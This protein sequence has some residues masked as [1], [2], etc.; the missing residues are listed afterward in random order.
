MLPPVPP[1][2]QG[3]SYISYIGYEGPSMMDGNQTADS[4][5]DDGLRL[6]NEH[7]AMIEDVADHFV[8]GSPTSALSFQQVNA[9]QAVVEVP[10][11]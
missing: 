1:V 3:F 6:W 9:H 10:G 4:G 5:F 8:Q 7:V 2:Y 11:E